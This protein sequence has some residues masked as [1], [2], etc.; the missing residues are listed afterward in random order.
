MRT[1][2][3]DMQAAL[4][5]EATTLCRCWELVRRDG[6]RMGFTDHD[7]DLEIEG[8]VFEAAAGL[9]AGAR[10]TSTGLSVDSHALAGALSSAAI[11]ERDVELG[12]Y[13]GAEVTAWLV[14]WT[15]PDTRMILAA[16]TLGAVTRRGAAF[17]AEVM[18]RA[19]ALNRPVGRAFVPH[20]HL[21][22]GEP[23]CGVDLED[24]AF[25]GSGV[26]VERLGASLFRV[27]GLDGFAPGLF[28][29]GRLVWTVGA[30]AGAVAHVRR[31]A[32]LAGGVEIET[33]A[34]PALEVAPG[35]AC[36]ITAG[37]DKRL[38]TCRD[39]F[40]NL[41]NFRG[42]PHM[43]GDDWA[44]GYPEDGG[45]HDGSSLYRG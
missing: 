9:A 17:E 27:S 20:C 32:A 40:A 45:A 16:G 34:A 38:E 6:V 2:S 14:D 30:N 5:A 19:E 15:S 25:T 35:D 37:C 23:R 11:S 1:L 33:W 44:T 36:E 24:P 8:V 13:D 26:V 39:R 31:H 21:R 18:G 28:D 3:P 43:P 7:R 10:E 4:A 41:M 12:L 22:L 42:F 29:D